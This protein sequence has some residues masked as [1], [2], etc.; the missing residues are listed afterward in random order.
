MKKIVGLFCVIL[1]L[2]VLISNLYAGQEAVVKESPADMKLV[3]VQGG[4]FQMGDTFGDWRA[5]GK[6]VHEV[7][8]KNFYMGKYE[9]TQ[10]QWKKIMGSNPSGFSSCGDECPVEQVSWN[11]VQEFIS[12]LNSQSGKKYRLPTEAEWEYAARSGGKKEKWAGTSSEESLVDYAWYKDNSEGKTHAVGQKKPNALGLYDMGG[13]V[14]E[15]CSDWFG[16]YPSGH[17]TDPIGSAAGSKR[18]LR[19][20]SWLSKPKNVC[21]AERSRNT[22]D[23]RSSNFG[24]RLVVPAQ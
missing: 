8:V 9:V 15:W 19:G 22:P 14:W 17:V 20:G 3:F 24:F 2:C 7:C 21:A 13:N 16:T 1:L 18:V 23:F 11:D 4:C 6:P 10:G 5:N 12:K